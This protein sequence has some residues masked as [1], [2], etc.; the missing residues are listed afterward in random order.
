MKTK[1]PMFHSI[2]ISD[3]HLGTK[4]SKANEVIQFLRATRCKR[5]I[6]NGDII[7]GWALRSG[8]KWLP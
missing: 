8:G 7:D 1:K 2:I 6:L 5:L 3:V 4:D